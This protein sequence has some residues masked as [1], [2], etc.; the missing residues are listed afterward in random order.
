MIWRWFEGVAFATLAIVLHLAIFW[1]QSGE[2]GEI[3][4]GAGGGSS[5]TMA[6]ATA[7][8]SAL[9]AEWDDVPEPNQTSAEMTT[10]QTEQPEDIFA[11]QMTP[12]AIGLPMDAPEQPKTS[13]SVTPPTDAPTTAAVSVATPALQMPQSAEAPAMTAPTTPRAGLV[14]PSPPTVPIVRKAAVP[15]IES[16]PIVQPETKAAE[17]APAK[18]PVPQK[19][20]KPPKREVAKA[21]PAKPK[22]PTKFKAVA[23]PQP[24]Q[25]TSTKTA[26]LDAKGG[27]SEEAVPTTVATGTS[28]GAEAG[29]S[30]AAKTSGPNAAEKASLEQIWGGKIRRSVERRKRYPRSSRRSGATQIAMTVGRNGGLV[31]ASIKRGSGHTTL[32]KAAM[33]AVKAAAPYAPAPIELSGDQFTFVLQI[34][35]KR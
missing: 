23:K 6:G 27:T 24:A 30:H 28:G 22:A 4:G 17:S 21:A 10:D 7:E 20:P 11:E 5:V 16:D 13:P 29:N 14:V 1:A 18:A 31:A 26:K 25:K 33:K 19:R 15:Q 32:D 2:I 34:L 8:M 12:L 9:I 3:A 35:F